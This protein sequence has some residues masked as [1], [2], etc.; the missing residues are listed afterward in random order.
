MTD[1]RNRILTVPRFNSLP[2]LVHGFGTA[3]WAERDF[4]ASE[5]L[6][7][8]RPVY[9]RQIHTDIVRAPEE[10]LGKAPEGDAWAT[11][12]PGFL[13][14]IKTA[15]CLPLLLVDPNRRA[16]GAVHCGWKSTLLGIA[17][18]AVRAMKER[19]GAD[20]DSMI[21][22]LGPCIETSC[23]EIGPEVDSA[24][25]DAGLSAVLTPHPA[26][27]GRSLLDLRAANRHQLLSSGMGEDNILSLDFCTRCERELHSWRRDRDPAARM[28][29]FIGIRP[30]HRLPPQ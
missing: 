7:S 9:L 10:S 27:S 25:R 8:L 13:L 21:A 1:D 19:C 23:L 12:R 6:Q 28:L 15:D 5:E 18:T 4:A 20:P 14:V 30:L 26:A 17:A 11:D 3:A 2:W 22:A 16:V 24:F 29:N